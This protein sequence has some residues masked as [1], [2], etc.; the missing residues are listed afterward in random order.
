MRH[1]FEFYYEHVEQFELQG[2]QVLVLFAENP[3]GHY[4]RHFELF[5]NFNVEV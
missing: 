5:K 3:S 1:V 4:E 2:T